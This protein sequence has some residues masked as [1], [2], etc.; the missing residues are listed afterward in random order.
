MDERKF[1]KPIAG[2]WIG[3]LE[4]SHALRTEG[5]E[6]ETRNDLETEA[7]VDRITVDRL[8]RDSP[9]E[10]P[11]PS[12]PGSVGAATEEHRAR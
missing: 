7:Q 12:G 4:I 8:D 11:G 10:V 9:D 3:P 2:Q 5:R 6:G 1:A